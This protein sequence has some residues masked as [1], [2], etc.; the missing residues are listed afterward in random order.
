MDLF[1]IAFVAVFFGVSVALAA[2]FDRIGRRK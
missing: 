1:F 2:A